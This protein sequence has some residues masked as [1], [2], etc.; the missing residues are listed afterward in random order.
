MSNIEKISDKFQLITIKENLC[1]NPS[2][3][4]YNLKEFGKDIRIEFSKIEKLVYENNGR[5]FGGYIRDHLIPK[6]EYYKNMY[7][8]ER[9][10]KNLNNIIYEYNEPIFDFNDLDI[11]F[12]RKRDK[13]KFLNKL[14]LLYDKTIVD[15]TDS[16]RDKHYPAKNEKYLIRTF[17]ME[18]TIDVIC[19]SV[20]P[21]NDFSVNLISYDGNKF[22]VEEILT[23]YSKMSSEILNYTM[24]YK[25]KLGQ[26]E[27]YSRPLEFSLEDIFSHIRNKQMVLLYDYIDITPYFN[28]KKGNIEYI[29]EC[30]YTKF[31]KLKKYEVIP[32]IPRV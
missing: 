31:T 15:I 13:K 7:K 9:I 18:F 16:L 19:S 27:Y 3:I 6:I 12:S 21:V 1:I 11:Y 14:K 8:I 32:Y 17:D 20:F 28:G 29:K 26:M 10:N 2:I 30:R 22:K 4:A 5:C 24:Y 23:F 25:I